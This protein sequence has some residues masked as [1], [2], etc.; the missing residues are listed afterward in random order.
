[1]KID[2]IGLFE[3]IYSLLPSFGSEIKEFIVRILPWF[4][5]V[6]GALITLASAMDFIG[7]TFITSFT[8][9]GDGPALIQQLLLRSVL[10]ITQGILMIF[11]FPALKRHQQK[12]WRLLFWS[13]MLWIIAALV[14]LNYS[15]ILGFVIFY[16]IFQVRRYYN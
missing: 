4:T 10:G 5:L 1:M 9:G 7:S 16:P 13:Q 3:K 12:G 2:I 14:S 15:V 8:L 6:F 11:A